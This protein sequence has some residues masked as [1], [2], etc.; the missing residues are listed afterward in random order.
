M[1]TGFRRDGDSWVGP[2]DEDRAA[3]TVCSGGVLARRALSDEIYRGAVERLGQESLT[4]LVAIVGHFCIVS[5]TLLAFDIQPTLAVSPP[6][7]AS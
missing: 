3:E 6:L 4:E 5:L 2:R 1:D 7:S